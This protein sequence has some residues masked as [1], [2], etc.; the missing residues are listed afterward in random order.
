MRSKSSLLPLIQK[1]GAGGSGY[2][3]VRLARS[4]TQ[5]QYGTSA[6]RSMARVNASKLPWMSA[7]APM[8]IG[9][10]PL[11]FGLWPLA[12][13]QRPGTKD[14]KSNG[15]LRDGSRRNRPCG[16]SDEQIRLVPDEV[17]LAVDGQ[18][19]VLAHED[20]RHRAGFLA[21]A[22]E[23]ATRLVDLVDRRV[24]RPG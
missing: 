11:V 3:P 5:I 7:T 6:C 23:D 12:K 15:L 2:A 13:H 14:Q 4:P 18:L 10:W 20:R 17:V 19:V 8:I 9:P 22:A 1:S 21:V 24:T 16:R